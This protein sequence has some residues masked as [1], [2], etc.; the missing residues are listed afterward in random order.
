MPIAI[1]HH[2]L[3]ELDNVKS[4]YNFDISGVAGFF[5]G[6]VAVAA[7]S[8]VHIY[9]GRK[10]L[11][12]Y[13]SPG[14]Y[15]I[16]KSYGVLCDSRLWDGLY[17]GVNV[18]PAVLFGLDGKD[19]PA[20]RG[21]HSG[22]ILGKTGQLGYLLMEECRKANVEPRNTAGGRISKAATL[23]V[24]DLQYTPA[25]PELHPALSGEL[26]TYLAF[27][28]I[29]VTIFACILCVLVADD[30]FSFALILYGAFASGV[31]C[32]VIGSGDLCV[33]HPTPAEG[34]PLGD[35]ILGGDG[36]DV[37]L[38]LGEEGA[39]NT[40]TR[41][42]F[43]LKFPGKPQYHLIGICAL[44]L[45]I[46][47]LAQLL[48]I[49]LGTL[50]GQL[51]FL[52]S[53]AASWMYTAY[54][55]SIDRESLQR[56]I[57]TREILQNP[58]KTKYKFG[59]RT[60]MSVFLLLRLLPHLSSK[61]PEQMKTALIKVLDELLPNDT[62]DWRQWRE[63]TLPHIMDLENPALSSQYHS[64]DQSKKTP[65]LKKLLDDVDAAVQLYK[66]IQEYVSPT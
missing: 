21:V 29:L 52:A 44:L 6:D 27:F 62:S 7:M 1:F 13:N 31:S 41:G 9:R 14:S 45:T 66:C 55:A 57:V 58:Q 5:G 18:D 47:F 23:T 59:T 51:M 11:G 39:V 53:L 37:I 8:T 36:E 12:W 22:T 28:P 54:L 26:S 60:A 16:A 20:F 34:V 19:G 43:S 33:S 56:Q 10:W 30:W 46:Q 40:I 49:P 4:K 25:K 48:V 3:A 2:A 63:M 50:F 65:L 64:L 42:R 15:D 32:L 61:T 17:P 38:L 35:G 24:V